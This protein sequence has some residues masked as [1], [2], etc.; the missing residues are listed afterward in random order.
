MAV[1]LSYKV[2]GE[3]IWHNVTM[4]NS[5]GNT[6]VGEILGFSAGT[7]VYYKIIAYDHSG[8]VAVEDNAGS[9]YIYTVV[10]EFPS[11]WLLLLALTAVIIVTAFKF[12]KKFQKEMIR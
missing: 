11:E 9:Y 1:I 10:S 4:E 7:L 2:A 3:D 6:Y 12:R 8:N 5:A